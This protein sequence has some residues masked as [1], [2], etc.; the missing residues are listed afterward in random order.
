MDLLVYFLS[1]TLNKVALGIIVVLFLL[2]LLGL[3]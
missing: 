1:P 3:S 2:S